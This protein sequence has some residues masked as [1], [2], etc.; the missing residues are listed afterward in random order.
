MQFRAPANAEEATSALRV[1]IRTITTRRVVRF[2]NVPMALVPPAPMMKSP[3][4]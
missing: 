4:P 3:S 2:T 1:G